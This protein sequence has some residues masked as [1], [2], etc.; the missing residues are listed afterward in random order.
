MTLTVDSMATPTHAGA[1]VENSSEA[2]VDDAVTSTLPLWQSLVLKPLKGGW[3]IVLVGTL[4]LGLGGTAAASP[5]IREPAQLSYMGDWTSTT[6]TVVIRDIT[7]AN[8]AE[9]LE[10][11]ATSERDVRWL[12]QQS[13]LTWDQLGRVFG[14]SRRAVH[15]WANGSRLNATNAELLAELVSVVRALPASDPAHRRAALL[16]TAADG[17]SFLDALR[18]RHTEEQPPINGPAFAPEQLLGAR[19]EWHVTEQ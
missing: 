18:A 16:A 10:A 13:G 14:V 11:S 9:Q 15:M 7:E 6:G 17:R 19:H 3:T 5:S 1:R 2:S 12:H 4:G 8:V